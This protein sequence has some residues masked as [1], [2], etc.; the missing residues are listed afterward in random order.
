MYASS[1]AWHKN[2]EFVAFR[3]SYLSWQG[4]RCDGILGTF[5]KPLWSECSVTPQRYSES[6]LSANS[7]PWLQKIALRKHLILEQAK[8]VIA[9]W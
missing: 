8:C 2:S 6:S 7:V 9:V 3:V 1:R 4:K 5:R